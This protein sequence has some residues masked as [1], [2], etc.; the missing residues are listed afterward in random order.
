[1]PVPFVF[2]IQPFITMRSIFL[3]ICLSLLGSSSA[4]FGFSQNADGLTR[5]L[6]TS[7]GR[8]ATN[9]TFDY[10]VS[11]F[12]MLLIVIAVLEDGTDRDTRSSEAVLPA[13][14]WPID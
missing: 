4:S 5:L 14:F 1:M 7:F 9:Q 6:G 11:S 2:E 8:F 3:S 10:V 13:L 12:M